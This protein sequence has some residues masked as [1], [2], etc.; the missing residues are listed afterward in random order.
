MLLVLQEL[1]KNTRSVKCIT[2]HYTRFHQYRE[3]G[4]LL[5]DLDLPARRELA[6][7][8]HAGVRQ[9]LSCV[10]VLQR[11]EV[12]PLSY[13]GEQKHVRHE[14]QGDALVYADLGYLFVVDHHIAV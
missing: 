12:Q 11:H 10:D 4:S 6:R 13:T 7:H 9:V 14:V 5:L 2:P 8:D 3:K 1:K